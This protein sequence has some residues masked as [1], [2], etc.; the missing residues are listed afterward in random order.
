MD[1]AISGEVN[2]GSD[3]WYGRWINWDEFIDGH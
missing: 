2:A 3:E 1:V